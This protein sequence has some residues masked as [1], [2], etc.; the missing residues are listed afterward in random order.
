MQISPTQ[1]NKDQGQKSD[2]KSVLKASHTS[3]TLSEC[4]FTKAGFELM[5]R[6]NSQLIK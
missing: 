6:D 1:R 3:Q 2:E 4:N 5:I